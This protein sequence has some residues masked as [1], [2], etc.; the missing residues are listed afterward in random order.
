MEAVEVEEEAEVER[1]HRASPYS[2]TPWIGLNQ[3]PRNLGRSVLVASAQSR[4]GRTSV[5]IALARLAALSGRRTI[6]VDCDLRRPALHSAFGIKVGD[7]V[8]SIHCGSRGLG[9][10]IG[11]EFLRQMVIAAPG[12][13]LEA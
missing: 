7:I 9:H 3:P 10:Q 12:H 11:T 2:M 13:G 1:G 8:V 6:L 4:E 5:A